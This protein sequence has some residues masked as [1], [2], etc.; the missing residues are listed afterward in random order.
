MKTTSVVWKGDNLYE[1]IGV[2]GASLVANQM[3]WEDYEDTVRREGLEV[4]TSDGPVMVEVG[5]TIINSV[6][7]VTVTHTERELGIAQQLEEIGKELEIKD[8]ALAMYEKANKRL[9]DIAGEL[10]VLIQEKHSYRYGH[11]QDARLNNVL[12]R[13]ELEMESDK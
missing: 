4:F 6:G 1:V 10:A 8:Y 7:V 2:I 13:L 5:D 11:L 9:K 12:K 3:T